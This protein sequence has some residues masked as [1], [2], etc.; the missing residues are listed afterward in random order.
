MSD[1]IYDCVKISDLDA[2]VISTC[3][4]PTRH[5]CIRHNWTYHAQHACCIIADQ[6]E[7]DFNCVV[8]YHMPSSHHCLMISRQRRLAVHQPIKQLRFRSS[9]CYLGDQY[10]N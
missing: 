6:L 5:I 1:V 9:I 8:S 4:R 7:I 3:L 10:I 2:K